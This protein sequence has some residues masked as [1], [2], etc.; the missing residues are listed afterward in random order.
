MRADG[1]HATFH[2]VP[3]H[4]SHPGGR[5]FDG[6]EKT[7]CPMTDDVGGRLL[8]LPYYTSLA[9]CDATRRRRGLSRRRRV[10]RPVTGTEVAGRTRAGLLVVAALL[11]G[12]AGAAT[13]IISERYLGLADFAPLA[14]LWTF[15]AVFAAGLTFSFQQWAAVHEV[16]RRDIIVGGV[17]TPRRLAARG[18]LLRHVGRHRCV[19]RAGLPLF[20]VG[21]AVRSCGTSVRHRPERRPSR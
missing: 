17:A 4:S 9:E 15:W 14:Q 19:P 12:V 11:T 2:Y 5:R 18:S 13:L 6:Y 1:V 10:V 8:R 16:S 7:R 3:L 20:V 21:L